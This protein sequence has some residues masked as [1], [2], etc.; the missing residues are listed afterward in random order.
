MLSAI[1]NFCQYYDLPVVL[2]AGF[3]IVWLFMNIIGELLEFKGKVVPE[4]MKIRKYFA[5]KKK[6]RE[7]L[8][9]LPEMMENVTT[10]LDDVNEHYSSDNITKRNK[11]IDVVNCRLDNHEIIVKEINDK[12]D[13]N[14]SDILDLIVD[15][16]RDAII[17]FA[18]KVSDDDF[19]ATREQF[20]R[21]FKIYE[22]YERIIS[23]RGL[24]NGEIDVAYK[25]I[26]EAYQVR[27]KNHTFIEDIRWH[28]LEQ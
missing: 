27:L 17:S 4:C 19:R 2:L 15:N 6:E 18:E 12:L 20:T 7:T 10:L 23:E 26:N 22:E 13:R 21:I 16:K 9:S 5:R 25:I 8:A 28:G 3:A 11:W 14:S 1:E 24:T